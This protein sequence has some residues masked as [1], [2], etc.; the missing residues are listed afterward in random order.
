MYTKPIPRVCFQVFV[1]QGT[2]ASL[3]AQKKK[4]LFIFC[5][6]PCATL[7]SIYNVLFTPCSGER[8]LNLFVSFFVVLPRNFISF[9]W[10]PAALVGSKAGCVHS[11]SAQSLEFCPGLC[12]S[13]YNDSLTLQVK[14]Y[15]CCIVTISVWWISSTSLCSQILHQ[16]KRGLKPK[17][18]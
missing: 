13:Q 7:R 18:G 12:L 6:Q 10:S 5:V 4:L 16:P 8:I 9:N 15:L 1:F 3:K 17:L 14:K 2:P 11:Y